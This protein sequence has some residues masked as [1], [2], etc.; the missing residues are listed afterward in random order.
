VALVLLTV[1]VMLR[2]RL[3]P[4]WLIGVGAVVGAFGLAG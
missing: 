4:M 3:S 1:V 2:T